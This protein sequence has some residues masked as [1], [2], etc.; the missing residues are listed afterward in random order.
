MFSVSEWMEVLKIKM[1]GKTADYISLLLYRPFLPRAHLGT[2]DILAWQ[3][4]DTRS[5]DHLSLCAAAIEAKCGNLPPS[6]SR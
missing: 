2:S 5:S 6:L 1:E 3:E 4:K